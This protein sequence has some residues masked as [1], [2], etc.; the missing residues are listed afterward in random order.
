MSTRMIAEKCDISRGAMLHHY[1]TRGPLVEAIVARCFFKR[2]EMLADGLRNMSENQRIQ[3]LVGLEILWSSY[4]TRE[5]RAYLEL[6]IASR[7]DPGL[8]AAF[9]PEAQRFARIARDAGVIIFPEWVGDPRRQ[10]GASDL[11][12]VMLE[13]T[14]RR[15][16]PCPPAG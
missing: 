10:E 14:L 15:R 9:L 11:V 5:H 16:P 3:G 4:F 2:V 12:E 7:V 1:P 8:R 13:V 6:A